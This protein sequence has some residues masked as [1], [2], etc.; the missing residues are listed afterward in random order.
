M[1]IIAVVFIIGLIEYL[2]GKSLGTVLGPVLSI[3]VAIGASLI[4]LIKSWIDRNKQ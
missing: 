4:V 1:Q 3:V 2:T